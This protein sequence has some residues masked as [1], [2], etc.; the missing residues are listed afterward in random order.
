MPNATWLITGTNAIQVLP[1][2]P[3]R[4][5]ADGGGGADFASPYSAQPFD[6][7]IADTSRGSVVIN[8][9]TLVGRGITVVVKHDANTSLAANTVTVNGPVSPAV[10][11]EQPEPNQGTFGSSYQFPPPGTP[12]GNKELFRGTKLAWFNGGSVGGYLL[13]QSP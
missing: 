3:V 13:D 5:T 7:V 9:P 2:I 6:Y 10:N 8:I 1:W 12:S 11:L 4:V